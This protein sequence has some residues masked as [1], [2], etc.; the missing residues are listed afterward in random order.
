MITDLL[1]H[2]KKVACRKKPSAFRKHRLTE[3]D[4]NPPTSVFHPNKASN[5]MPLTDLLAFLTQ[6]L[7]L[8]TQL[9]EHNIHHEEIMEEVYHMLL[10]FLGCTLLIPF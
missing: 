3:I 4:L 7:L 8:K 10:L 9:H 1:I 6:S 5:Q 2:P